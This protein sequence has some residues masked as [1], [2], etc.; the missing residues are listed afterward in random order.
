MMP[1]TGAALL[2]RNLAVPLLERALGSGGA[3]PPPALRLLAAAALS[4]ARQLCSSAAVA[5][6][7]DAGAA[8]AGLGAAAA[9]EDVPVLIA[10]GGP[11]GLTTALLLAKCGVRS[12][13]LEK[14]RT[15]TDHPQ[16]HLINMR[17]MEVFRA[18]GDPDVAARVVQQMPPLEQWRRFVYCTGMGGGRVLGMV[19]HF[20]GQSSPYQP[21]ISPEPVAHLAQHRLLPLLVE[22][23]QAEPRIELRMGHSL[24]SFSQS[25]ES[26]NALVDAA[27]GSSAG[28]AGGTGG[29]LYRVSARYL[30][31]ADGTRGATRQQLG[32]GMGGPGA[33]QHLINI[34]FVS[35]ELG[36]KLRGREG[37]LYFVFN[38]DAIAV[39]VA[40]NIDSG[41]FVAQVPFFPP[42]QSGA[43]FTPE[44][45]KE[46][47]RQIARADVDVEVKTIRPWTMAGRVA[48]S[49]R[50]GRVFLVGD[51]AHAFPP[52]GAFGMNTGVCDAHNLAWKLAAVLQGRA[53]DGLLDTYTPE[54]KQVGTANMLLSVA[55]FNEALRVPQILGL[56]YKAANLLSDVLAAPA[57]SFLPSELRKGMLETAMSVGKKAASPIRRLR[58]SELDEVFEHGETLRLQF[59]K[60]DLGY[61]YSSVVHGPGD[62]AAVADYSKPRARD[63]PYTP[64][65]LV[66]ARLPHV[67]VAVRQPGRLLAQAGSQ[68]VASTVDLAAAAGTSLLLLL[69][70]GGSVGAWEQAA[71]SA[72]AATGVPLLPVLVAQSSLPAGGAA[73]AAAGTTVV[74]DTTGGWLRLRDVPA[75]GALLVR[76][77]GHI[78][79]RHAGGPIDAKLESA[80]RAVMDIC[81]D[82]C[83]CGGDRKLCLR[84]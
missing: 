31:A 74:Q 68:R 49:Y 47:V 61:V 55:N 35:P 28:G 50:S 12:L 3:A 53:G 9:A 78:C 60:E 1:S 81:C 79:W 43:E 56:D 34:H 65:T 13:V 18:L 51:A 40:H 59:P 4:G 37:M 69:S 8:G 42:L 83:G 11:T 16:A 33:I 70:E 76:P 32:I 57:L 46:L 14:A 54:R 82:A 25:P 72:E 52:S 48:H 62:A 21:A 2:A 29:G 22:A 64:T 36:R 30:A 41:E 77:D 6:A 45:C 24:R 71:A 27:P 23:A 5:A 75:E 15:L 26:V 66:G 38:R 17:C 39:V 10:G 7:A 19:D 67:A 73:G 80:V 84:R 44:K 63:A 58:Q 20:K